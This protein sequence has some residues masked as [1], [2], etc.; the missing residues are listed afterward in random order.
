MRSR[1]ISPHGK[2]SA[3]AAV[4]RIAV[5]SRDDVIPP[6]ETFPQPFHLYDA[7]S[8]QGGMA[9]AHPFATDI[10]QRHLIQTSH[11]NLI[12]FGLV[13]TG[14]STLTALL[15]P[16]VSLTA[17]GPLV[18][19]PMVVFTCPGPAST[20]NG[21]LV[22]DVPA[23]HRRLSHLIQGGQARVKFEQFRVTGQRQYLAAGILVGPEQERLILDYYLVA[24]AGSAVV[25]KFHV[26]LVMLQHIIQ[27]H[28]GVSWSGVNPLSLAI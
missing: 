12:G 22:F 24:N 16:N 20:D 18:V 17:A 6:T 19:P 9:N 25:Q 4:G 2:S 21:L 8:A 28:C 13:K 15:G 7:P 27:R 14:W 10:G 5:Y 26:R 23:A 3:I 1:C 11:G